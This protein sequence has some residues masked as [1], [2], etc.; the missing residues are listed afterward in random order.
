MFKLH[1]CLTAI[2]FTAVLMYP[3]HS[4]AESDAKS[5]AVFIMTNAADK[6]EVIAYERA[7]NGSLGGGERYKT[8]GRGSG[9]T[10]DP[11]GSQGSLTLSQDAS[12][13]FAANAG[14][15]TVSVFS[16]RRSQ[17]TFLGKT[18]SGGSEPVAVAENQSL[19]YVLN[20][21]G[22]GSVV[23]FRLD[24]G[25]QL[26]QIKNSTTFLTAAASGGSS[27]TL[28]PDG[29]FLVVTEKVANNIDVFHI[30]HDGTLGPIVANPS[31]VPGLFAARFAPNGTLIVSST[32]TA[33][34]A[35]SSTISSFSIL[36]TGKISPVS[37]GVFTLG[38]ANCWNAVTPNGKFA[39]V[40]N[41]GSSSISGFEIGSNGA[42]TPLPGTVVGNNPQGSGNLDITIS[43]DGRFIYTLNSATGDIGI[44]GIEA[45]GSLTNLGA[46]GEYP[47]SLG[48]N[49]IAAL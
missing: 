46:G 21:G 41:A 31:P 2:A 36:P 14:S 18:P 9:G 43:V 45:D 27:L 12:L 33:G 7:S 26:K 5:G 49:G 11:L 24:F 3:L 6:N 42:L 40:S 15:G 19:V 20:A 35:N 8:E 23:G 32:G 13:L 22:A 16:V 1:R 39:Y 29:Q 10:N 30:N 44:F 4:V 37:E 47:K 25:G 17:L 28:S 48:F 34:V 38:T